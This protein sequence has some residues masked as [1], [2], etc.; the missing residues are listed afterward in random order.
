MA[1]RNIN[2][3]Q[4]V[5][6]N[7]DDDET[8]TAERNAH[9]FDADLHRP[10]PV[11]I[12]SRA[13]DVTPR[14]EPAEPAPTAD[15]QMVSHLT[16]LTK[17]ESL[18]ESQA[19]EMSA[20]KQQISA[21]TGQLSSQQ[22]EITLLR[23]KVTSLEERENSRTPSSEPADSAP[24]VDSQMNAYLARLAELEGL[25]A[26]QANEISTLKQRISE[27]TDQISS[28]QA[29]ITLLRARVASLEERASRS[30]APQH[31]SRSLSFR[32]IF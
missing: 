31:R 17:L 19:S 1:L 2:V 16:R 7:M 3:P 6:V 18:F 23:N 28:Q 22:D 32:V 26:S 27:Q 30:Q 25:F 29:D 5:Y 4:R 15:S 24:T 14:S 12:A 20:M 21:Q 13:E 10:D 8:F 9:E 11:S